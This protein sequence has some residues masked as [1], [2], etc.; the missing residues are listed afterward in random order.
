GL[1]HGDA[2]G[3]VGEDD[4]VER[5]QLDFPVALDRRSADV[6]SDRR[7]RDREALRIERPAA[8]NR[9]PEAIA[10][11]AVLDERESS[12]SD[13]PHRT[14]HRVDS[15]A[16]FR[17]RRQSDDARTDVGDLGG[18]DDGRVWVERGGPST[19][20]STSAG[21][22]PPTSVAAVAVIPESEVR[23]V[24]DAWVAAQ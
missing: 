13:G 10:A 3:L 8:R 18:G 14:R 24:V 21:A 22:A 6:V 4:V 11:A 1:E 20:T 7:V 19:S 5:A 9:V 12:R 2:A 15:K 16:Q 23:S 17:P